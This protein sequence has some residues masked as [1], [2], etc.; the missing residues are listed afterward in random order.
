[1]DYVL[2]VLV[3][4]VGSLASAVFG[5]GTALLVLAVGAHILPVKE[6]IALATVLF[7][8]S[9]V[10]KTFLFSRAIDWRAI[11]IMVCSSVPFA[12]L[13][14][15][16]MVVVPGDVLRRTLGV[17]V[18]LY[19]LLRLTDRLPRF[20]IGTGGLIAGSAL[21][22]FVSGLLGSGNV[23]KV[24]LFR[25]MK[26]S[27]EA[28]VGAMAASAVLN[29]VVKLASYTSNGLLTTDMAAPIAALVASGVV[30]AF[31]GRAV[32]KRIEVKVFEAGVQVLLGIA[33]AT[34]LI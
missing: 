28:F 10:T 7:A 21:Y 25:E 14:A 4:L 12:W 29:N 9:T 8:A 32:L 11:A 24:V 2:F 23:V 5:F 13:G 19:L 15:D 20:T 33:A 27:K 26:I 30:A 22:G 16:L 6:T 1:M 18:L 34:L 17:M 31:V 3:G